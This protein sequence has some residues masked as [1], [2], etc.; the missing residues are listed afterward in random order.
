MRH[1][2]AVWMA[3]LACAASVPAARADEMTVVDP[4]GAGYAMHVTSL[5]E[6]RFKRTVKQQY[7]FSCGSAAVATLLTYQYGYPMTEQTAFTQM[8]ENGN[9]EKIRRQGF[10]LLDIRRFLEAHGFVADGYELPL[11]TLA[12]THTPAIVL[13]TEHGYHHFVVVKGL[14]NGRVLVGDPATGTRPVTLASFEQKWED[15]VIFVIHNKPE[16]AVFNDP[17]DWRVAPSAPLYTGIN[18]DGLYNVVMPKHG[19]SDF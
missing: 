17:R 12:K 18:R 11:Q 14:R 15:H 10:S 6:A 9:Q 13:I 7:D 5:K 3:T 8:W 16:L 4:A 2:A 19:P 1:C